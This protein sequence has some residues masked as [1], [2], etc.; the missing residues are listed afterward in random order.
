MQLYPSGLLRLTTRFGA[1]WLH[2]RNKHL[3]HGAQPIVTRALTKQPKFAPKIFRVVHC[4]FACLH[5]GPLQ[6][7]FVSPNT[8]I[9]KKT[10]AM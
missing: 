8:K 10:K 9:N 6:V 5:H 2:T 7:R 4:W 1:F 3:L